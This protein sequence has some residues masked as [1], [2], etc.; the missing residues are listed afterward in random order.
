MSGVEN[1]FRISAEKSRT[2]GLRLCERLGLDPK[3]VSDRAMTFEAIG[4]DE[5]LVK[6]EGMAI[7]PAEDV[8]AILMS[9]TTEPTS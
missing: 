8:A 4:G 9:A 1:S 7:L 5:V 6:W 3:Q 2:I